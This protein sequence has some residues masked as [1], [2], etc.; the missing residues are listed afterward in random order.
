MKFQ[1]VF[2]GKK[3]VSHA[4]K[5]VVLKIF[6]GASLPDPLLPFPEHKLDFGLDPVLL[7]YAIRIAVIISSTLKGHSEKSN[8]CKGLYRYPD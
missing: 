6:L 4:E 8:A 3:G 2:N 1:V 5:G 7:L